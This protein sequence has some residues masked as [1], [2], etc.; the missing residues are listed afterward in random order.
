[1]ERYDER[2]ARIT[3]RQLLRIHRAQPALTESLL[4]A[5]ESDKT[6]PKRLSMDFILDL[7]CFSQKMKWLCEWGP[8]TIDE[9]NRS[10]SND[11]AEFVE[12][13]CRDLFLE[14]RIGRSD[15]KLPNDQI[16]AFLQDSSQNWDR[17]ILE[18]YDPLFF[19]YLH[20]HPCDEL[21]LQF[22]GVKLTRDDIR[23]I[24]K[25]TNLRRIHFGLIN[26]PS[27]FMQDL[28]RLP[29]LEV[30]DCLYPE[31][32]MDNIRTL[33]RFPR[34]TN[35][36][37]PI[38]PENLS[39]NDLQNVVSYIE[40]RR[41]YA[42]QVLIVFLEQHDIY[43]A[44]SQCTHLQSINIDGLDNPPENDVHLLF[45]SP[46]IQQSVRHVRIGASVG[47]R[48]LSLLAKCTNIRWLEFSRSEVTSAELSLIIR[49]NAHHMSTLK[50][51]ACY[52]VDDM[53]LGA[54]AGCRSL[55]SIDLEETGVS[56][57]VVEAYRASQL[58]SWQDLKYKESTGYPFGRMPQQDGVEMEAGEWEEY[59]SS[60]ETE[61]EFE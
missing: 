9:T 36:E 32:P 10:P 23:N 54:I 55:H 4:L 38:I 18:S 45:S 1:M 19:T 59:N 46:T 33:M 5:S 37:L 2:V 58:P 57:E 15:Q 31:T 3:K 24:A 61:S 53:L 42:R 29:D 28:Q 50:L 17:I 49:A 21:R 6:V 22:E 47:S 52:N 7:C 41:A 14:K 34:L 39:S 51:F 11:P 8:E 56:A 26:V 40:G 43:H 30:L 60:E 25:C 20:L 12:R 48:A 35:V 44:L 13:K 27:E 16:L